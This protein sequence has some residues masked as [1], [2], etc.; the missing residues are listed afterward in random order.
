MTLEVLGRLCNQ[1]SEIASCRE[2]NDMLRNSLRNQLATVTD[3][4]ELCRL[5]VT[6]ASLVRL[7]HYQLGT[8]IHLLSGVT[9][10]RQSPVTLKSVVRVTPAFGAE[11]A[12]DLRWLCEYLMTYA[13]SNDINWSRGHLECDRNKQ[14][15][16]S[17]ATH[18]VELHIGARRSSWNVTGPLRNYSDDI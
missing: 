10:S 14:D 1:K 18:L 17:D 12:T 11:L 13:H 16:P 3:S 2:I 9:L 4:E 6:L 15:L 5:Y 7:S 8:T